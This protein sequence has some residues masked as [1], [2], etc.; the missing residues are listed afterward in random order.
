MDKDIRELETE[1][2]QQEQRIREL[3]TALNKVEWISDDMSDGYCPWCNGRLHKEE[4]QNYNEERAK[5]RR[6]GGTNYPDL[7]QGHS[8]DCLR[9]RALEQKP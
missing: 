9:Q 3:E 1:N 8:D 6:V 5:L 4:V 7:I 2:K